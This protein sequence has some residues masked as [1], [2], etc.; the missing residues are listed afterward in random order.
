MWYRA[1][2]AA[3]GALHSS[4]LH[5]VTCLYRHFPS[6]ST[7]PTLVTVT[8]TPTNA[9]TSAVSASTTCHSPYSK[10]TSQHLHPTAHNQSVCRSRHRRQHE[11]KGCGRRRE[12]DA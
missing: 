1:G 2:T 5:L 6:P 12:D 4:P 3:H 9:L 11:R 10:A 7:A 8:T